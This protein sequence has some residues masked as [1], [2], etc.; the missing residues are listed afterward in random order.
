[1][2]VH[3]LYTS[4]QGI[5]ST[6]PR[7]MGNQIC[8]LTSW[9]TLQYGDILSIELYRAQVDQLEL[10]P[11]SYRLVGRGPSG[12][13]KTTRFRREIVGWGICLRLLLGSS[14]W[15]TSL[16]TFVRILT[17]SWP[18]GMQSPSQLQVYSYS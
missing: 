11:G 17:K 7:S 5:T 15:L 8:T 4:F 1:M 9:T 14:I 6:K 16:L 13:G 3:Q 18:L 2:S 12:T 10:N